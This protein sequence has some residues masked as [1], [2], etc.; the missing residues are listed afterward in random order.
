MRSLAAVALVAAGLAVPAAL[1]QAPTTTDTTTTTT[2]ATT[3]AAQTPL[4]RVKG[5]LLATA[6]QQ[7][8]GSRSRSRGAAPARG[9][10][11]LDATGA[12]DLAV[13]LTSLTMDLGAFARL[14]GQRRRTRRCGGWTS[15]STRSGSSC[16]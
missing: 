5:A 3:A 6:Q 10:L 8:Y 7:S 12:T 14:A 4:D 2:T 11:K 13:G 16:T 9:R 15:C 1:G